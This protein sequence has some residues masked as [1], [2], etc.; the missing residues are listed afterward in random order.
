[1]KIISWNVNGLRSVYKKNFLDWLEKS[2][3]DVALLQ[4]VK[5][6][7]AA[8]S[9]ETF[10]GLLDNQ[11]YSAYF[12]TARKP[13]Y[14]GVAAYVK[15]KPLEIEK[16]LLPVKRFAEEGRILKLNYPKFTLINFYL[17]H[18]G[19]L[20]EN[21]PYKLEVYD[22]LINYLKKVREENVIIAGDFNIA[23]QDIDL[24][25]PKDNRN[26]IMFTAEERKQIDRILELGFVDSFRKYH[27]EGGHYTWWPYRLDLRKRNV[28]WRLDY[29]FIS[30]NL[31]SKLKNAFI[32]P[33]VPG[34]DHCPVG[35]ELKD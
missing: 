11:T 27:A 17:P 23:H 29:I 21:L 10:P 35:V 28:G 13:G 16:T 3:A 6:H 14:S 22:H 1:M 20:K 19:R 33:D 18:G 32:L 26:N 2:G 25:R 15:Q 30:Q 12:N 8:L 4:E 24:A 31:A 7:E 9:P 34:S 5:A